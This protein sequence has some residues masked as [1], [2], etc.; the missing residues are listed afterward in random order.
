MGGGE[1]LGGFLKKKKVFWESRMWV[2]R[3]GL[4]FLVRSEGLGSFRRFC[5]EEGRWVG[6]GRRE[7][8]GVGR[9]FFGREREGGR[10]EGVKSWGLGW[11]CK[12]I[13]FGQSA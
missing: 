7:G 9:F 6:F 11:V 1:D 13:V 8:G 5:G 12:R 10:G 2:K 3:G 4:I